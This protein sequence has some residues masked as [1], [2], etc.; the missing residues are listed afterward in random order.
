MI[1]RSIIKTLFL[2]TIL[3]ISVVILTNVMADG[4]K[5][6]YTLEELNIKWLNTE[7]DKIGEFHD[8]LALVSKNKKYGYINTKGELV[9]ELIYDNARDFSEGMAAV[10][11]GYDKNGKGEASETQISSYAKG[12]WGYINT[13]G[14]VI[15]PIQ[16]DEAFQ[17]SEGIAMVRTVQAEYLGLDKKGKIKVVLEDGTADFFR[18]DFRFKDGLLPLEHIFLQAKYITKNNE[19]VKIKELSD[20]SIEYLGLFSEGLAKVYYLS[21]YENNNKSIC[22]VNKKGKIVLNN[23][24]KKY[25]TVGEH[26][27][28]LIQV[29]K[30]GS[31]VGYINA[32]GEEVVPPT[33]DEIGLFSEGLARVKNNGNIY[34]INNKGERIINLDNKYLN[35]AVFSDGLAQV[36]TTK[37]AYI[38]KSGKL[39]TPLV[40]EETTKFIDSY[41]MVK[42]GNKVGIIK[43]PSTKAKKSEKSKPSETSNKDENSDKVNNE[44][45]VEQTAQIDKYIDI[46]KNFWARENIQKA[47]N[48]GIISGITDDNFAPNKK[49]I[50]ATVISAICKMSGD[51]V[52]DANDKSYAPYIKWAVEK[53]ISDGTFPEKNITREQFVTMLY[54]YEN[55]PSQSSHLYKFKDSK[56]VSSWAKDAMNWAIENSYIEG[57]SNSTIKPKNNITRA[58]LITVLLRYIDNQK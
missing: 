14:K 50:R 40:F 52:E 4:E 58:E 39:I 12:K 19:N 32:K 29:Y 51:K 57:Y 54:R 15:I 35:S 5:A 24:E 9:V 49:A 45:L 26:T 42:M 56:N 36:K 17:F 38:D 48:L 2:T 43:K 25:D 22:F 10:N 16:L 11:I 37:E 53:G 23:L 18:K 28:G 30:K 20:C 41:A 27:N 46:S 6:S 8:G 47:L 34:Y 1:K 44:N 3:L 13:K 31:G 33:N 21:N 7:Y 55:N